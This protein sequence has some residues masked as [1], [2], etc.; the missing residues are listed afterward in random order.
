MLTRF[1]GGSH[2]LWLFA[3]CANITTLAA[4]VPR[5]HLFNTVVLNRCEQYA[6]SLVEWGHSESAT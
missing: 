5:L 1:H 3:F 6:T 2:C 4:C